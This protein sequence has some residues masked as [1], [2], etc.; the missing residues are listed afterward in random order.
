MSKSKINPV[1][2][3]LH[4]ALPRAYHVH[5]TE[6]GKAQVREIFPGGALRAEIDASEL[7]TIVVESFG[8]PA[9]PEETVS[10][11]HG[12]AT[13]VSSYMEHMDRR[14]N[15]V[16]VV[17]EGATYTLATDSHACTVVRVDTRDGKPWRV[18][19]RR[20]E[21]TLLNGPDSGEPDALT[22]SP[23]GFVGH[24]SG[25]QRYSYK[26]DPTGDKYT[27][28]RRVYKGGVVRWKLVGHKSR[29]AGLSA[30]FRCRLEHYDFN[31]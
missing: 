25:T 6:R 27:V 30:H 2:L 24:M 3:A 29:A 18:L 15:G 14:E 16:P 13:F 5:V 22:F 28:T 12:V 20:D 31:F 26:P 1:L 9:V 23:G 19:L 11:G 8:R 7:W 10:S 21:A 17:G 4:A